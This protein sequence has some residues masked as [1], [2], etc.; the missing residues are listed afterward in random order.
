[1][2]ILFSSPQ[3]QDAQ[4]AY[5]SPTFSTSYGFAASDTNAFGVSATID[6]F[7]GAGPVTPI[8]TVPGSTVG[9]SSVYTCNTFPIS[10]STASLDCPGLYNSDI[11]PGTVTILLTSS[12]LYSG[13]YVF[14]VAATPTSVNLPYYF[15]NH[16]KT[17]NCLRALRAT[18]TPGRLSSAQAFCSSYTNGAA[19]ATPTYIPATCN[20]SRISSACTCIATTSA[21]TPT[22]GSGGVSQVK[23]DAGFAG[24]DFTYSNGDGPA[25]VTVTTTATEAP[26]IM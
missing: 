6:V 7:D 26:V 16:I 24:P 3:I 19:V 4:T 21:P 23:R 17:D 22:M 5:P 20:P 25:A 10:V 14:S 12:G 13:V 2:G 18:Q 1:M 11:L 15:L 8:V 9:Q